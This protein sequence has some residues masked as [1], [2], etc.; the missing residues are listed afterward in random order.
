MA[1]K[2][3]K[4]PR[5]PHVS[6]SPGLTRDERRLKSTHLLIGKP[7]VITEKLDG[8]N[9]CFQHEAVFARSHNGPLSHP[10]FNWLKSYHASIRSTIAAG[11]SA[12]AEY[13][14]AVHSIAYTSL[15]SSTFLFGVR[16]DPECRWLSWP[17]VEAQAAAMGIPTSPVLFTGTVNSEQELERLTTSLALRGS[18]YGGDCEGVVVRTVEGYSDDAFSASLAKWVRAGHV[19]TDDH[20]TSQA[21]RKQNITPVL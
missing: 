4:Y 10:S 2:H 12:F 18:V 5:T 20:W 8:S 19:Q 11:L 3:S 6:W 14:Y 17:E 1:T 21:I 7:I 13:C 16:N 15:P 9:V